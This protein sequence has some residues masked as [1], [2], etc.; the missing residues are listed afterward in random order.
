MRNYR[1]DEFM[2]DLTFP[3]RAFPAP[4]YETIESHTHDFYEL[5]CVFQGSGEHEYNNH[6]SPVSE[7]DVY[8]IAPHMTHG[9]R[10]QPGSP[11]FLY[12]VIF[13]P[14]VIAEELAV[15][16]KYPS[17]VDFFYVE[18]FLRKTAN[19]K[20][21]FNLK[22]SDR[23]DLKQTIDRLVD[24]DR[25]REPGY[26]IYIKTLII[27]L[28]IFLSRC[29]GRTLRKPSLAID[30]E[31]IMFRN[32]CDFIASHYAQPLTLTQLSRLCGI[33]QSS[34]TAKFKQYTDK[35]FIEYRNEIRIGVAKELLAKT[36]DKILSVAFE[37]GFDDFSF[38][39]KTFRHL[40]GMSPGQYRKLVRDQSKQP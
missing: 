27:Q 15:M 5:V 12:N 34:F 40:C 4:V 39:N 32:V 25:K 8:M 9:Y 21:H 19:F 35:T 7:G 29:Y 28:L 30:D 31:R 10:I 1:D 22:G 16:A 17:F 11:L 13:Q 2:D 36:D 33:S 23:I 14:S 18:P 24:E 6:F 3:F 37:V 38:F 26:Q 20:P